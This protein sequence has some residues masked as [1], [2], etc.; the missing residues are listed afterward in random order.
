MARTKAT[1]GQGVRLTDHLG[2]SLFARVYPLETVV[3]LLDKHGCNSRRVRSFPASTAVYFSMALSLYPE[4]AY[5][6]VFAAMTQGL[7]WMQ[8]APT[9]STVNKASITQARTKLGHAV[10]QELQGQCCTALADLEQHPDC[11]YGFCRIMHFP[12]SRHTKGSVF[13]GLRRYR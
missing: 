4:A 2:A 12:F 5:E 9:S 3:Q 11:F 7:A 6:D 13:V 10:L 8:D 1:L